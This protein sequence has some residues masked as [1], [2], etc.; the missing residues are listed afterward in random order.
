MDMH[1]TNLPILDIESGN[2]FLKLLL[3]FVHL[4]EDNAAVNLGC[5][6]GNMKQW[7]DN[8]KGNLPSVPE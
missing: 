4:P 5:G 2:I 1:L 8:L 3:A 7:G 6:K